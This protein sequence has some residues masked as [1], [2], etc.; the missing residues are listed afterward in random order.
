MFATA[1]ATTPGSDPFG[2]RS[3]VVKCEPSSSVPLLVNIPAL[4]GTAYMKLEIGES[5]EFSCY[6]G[7]A[8]GPLI[9]EVNMKTASSTATYGFAVTLS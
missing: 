4:H 5:L 7:R 8:A 3:V 2:V 6:Q 9:E 1:K